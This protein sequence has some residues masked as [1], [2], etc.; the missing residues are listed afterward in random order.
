MRDKHIA[1]LGGG[2]ILMS[3]MIIILSPFY[4]DIQDEVFVEGKTPGFTQLAEIKDE[5]K[6]QLHNNT[7]LDEFQEMVGSVTGEMRENISTGIRN[8]F[9]DD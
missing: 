5:A 2:L 6:G 3:L 7:A 1:G 8:T 9:S 4:D